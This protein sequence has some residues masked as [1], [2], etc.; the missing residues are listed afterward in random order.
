MF[1]FSFYTIIFRWF[2]KKIKIFFFKFKNRK[3]KFCLFIKNI[4]N[5]FKNHVNIIV[6]WK[7]EHIGFLIIQKRFKNNDNNA[8]FVKKFKFPD[9]KSTVKISKNTIFIILTILKMILTKNFTLILMQKT[10][11]NFNEYILTYKHKWSK[12]HAF[13]V[14]SGEFCEKIIGQLS[15]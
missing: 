8:F 3:F 6:K 12:N 1:Y 10:V 5:N 13:K 9:Q 7:I 14:Y 15:I 4:L 11:F 2:L